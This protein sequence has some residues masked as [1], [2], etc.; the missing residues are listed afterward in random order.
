MQV[1]LVGRP[2]ARPH[3]RSGG[4]V[5]D[6]F[7]SVDELLERR[8]GQMELGEPEI[9][10]PGADRE[11][12]LLGPAGVVVDEGVN[13][14]DGAAEPVQRLH[15]VRADE[16]GAAGD[17]KA[18]ARPETPAASVPLRTGGLGPPGAAWAGAAYEPPARSLAAER[19]DGCRCAVP[20]ASSSR[21]PCS[22]R[23]LAP[24]TRA[25][26]PRRVGLPARI[27]IGTPFERSW[28][29]SRSH[30]YPGEG[31]ADD[32]GKLRP[33]EGRRWRR[34]IKRTTGV[35]PATFGLGSRRSTN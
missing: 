17:E 32:S 13:A 26:L 11:V 31:Q 3:P 22:Q 2:P 29:G 23:R 7:D 30:A 9:A 35:E 33:P 24:W 20:L 4:E 34:L 1:G 15:E 19:V 27:R 8:L 14:D 5:E 25:S 12:P 6:S 18:P 28:R 10:S 16:A 21:L